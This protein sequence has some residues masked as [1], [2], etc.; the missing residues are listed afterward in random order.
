MAAALGGLDALI[1]TAG[2][3]EHDAATPAEVV[4]GCAWLGVTLMKGATGLA[5]AVS[6]AR[7]PACRRGSC[8]RRGADDFALHQHVGFNR[9]TGLTSKKPMRLASRH[10]RS[11]AFGF[12]DC[13][14]YRNPRSLASPRRAGSQRG[15]RMRPN[16]SLGRHSW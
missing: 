7:R 9:L 12:A 3:G 13:D 14:A 4:S 11:Q 2:I 8:H 1:F 16:W 5:G 10:I 15:T 6:A